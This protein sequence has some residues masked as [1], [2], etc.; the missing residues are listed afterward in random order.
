MVGVGLMLLGGAFL[1]DLAFAGIPY[2]DPPPEIEARYLAAQAMSDSLALAGAGFAA[3][4]AATWLVRRF[5]SR[6]A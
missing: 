2:Q 6:R 3:A 1:Y 4:G 5:T